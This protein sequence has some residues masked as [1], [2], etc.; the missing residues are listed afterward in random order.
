MLPGKLMEMAGLRKEVLV[1]GSVDHIEI[2][3]PERFEDST[4]GDHGDT[5]ENLAKEYLK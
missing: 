3:D 5:L 1:L 2:W 4:R